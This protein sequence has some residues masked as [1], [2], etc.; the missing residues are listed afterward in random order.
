VAISMELGASFEHCA[1]RA[2][3]FTPAVA[4]ARPAHASKPPIHDRAR[5]DKSHSVASVRALCVGALAASGRIVEA[6]SAGSRPFGQ[7]SDA[8]SESFR[9]LGRALVSVLP[10]IDRFVT[11]SIPVGATR[12]EDEART[13]Y[14]PIASRLSTELR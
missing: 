5:P 1:D 12:A 3:D 14:S 9:R 13:V 6:Q 10:A 2:A 11:S 4:D 8:L 7:V